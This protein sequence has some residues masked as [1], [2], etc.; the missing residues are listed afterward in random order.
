MDVHVWTIDSVEWQKR[1]PDS[2]ALLSEEELARTERFRDRRDRDLFVTGRQA[3]RILLAHYADR[4]PEGV[5]IAPDAYGKPVTDCGLQ[6]NISHT[7]DQLLLLG[8]SDS[9]IGVDIERIDPLTEIER[10]GERHFT[11]AEFLHLMNDEEAGRQGAFF[12]L[13]TKKESLAKGIG[14]G[15]RLPFQVFNVTD[16]NG[17]VRWDLTTGHCYGDWYVRELDI[18]PGYASA[19][20]TPNPRVQLRHFHM[21]G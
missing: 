20:A 9:P 2:H 7:R 12:K 18:Q 19:F 1:F 11:E 10:L 13:W 14:Q 5:T 16:G 17:R 21:D 8:F 3:S 15:L 6:F 4:A